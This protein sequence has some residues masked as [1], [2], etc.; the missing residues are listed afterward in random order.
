MS[1]LATATSWKR[2]SLS[3][4]QQ[5]WF[6]PVFPVY[7][8]AILN[9]GTLGYNRLLQEMNKSISLGFV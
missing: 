3:E 2:F 1:S 4:N 5:K 8:S 7:T 6:I 9:P